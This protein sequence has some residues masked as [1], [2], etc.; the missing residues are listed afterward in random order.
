MRDRRERRAA[1]ADRC[2]R[3]PVEDESRGGWLE[4]EKRSRDRCPHVPEGKRR[5]NVRVLNRS[6]VARDAFPD[7]RLRSFE[8]Q[9]DEPRM[10]ER[11]TDDCPSRSE[12][13]DVALQ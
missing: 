3:R 7:R 10:I 8:A 5:L 6:T 2:E 13:E 1:L 12:H 4:C 11:V 9:H